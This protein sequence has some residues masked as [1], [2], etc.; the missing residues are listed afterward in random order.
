MQLV[1]QLWALAGMMSTILYVKKIH[2]FGC[3]HNYDSL[4]I[5]REEA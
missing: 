3:L 5:R 2:E 4:R 1:G